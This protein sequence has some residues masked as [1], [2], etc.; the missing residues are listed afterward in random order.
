MKTNVRADTIE[1][2]SHISA[3]GGKLLCAHIKSQFKA[4]MYKCDFVIT[5]SLEASCGHIRNVHKC[6]GATHICSSTVLKYKRKNNNK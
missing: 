1:A 3:E 4:R 6:S 5:T 2:C